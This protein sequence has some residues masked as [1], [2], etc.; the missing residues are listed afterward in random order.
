M[1]T[2]IIRNEVKDFKAW[3]KVF[4]EDQPKIAAAGAKL[5]GL[6]TSVDNPN[7]VTMIYEAPAAELYDQ[8][9]SDPER[10]AEIERAGVIGTPTVSFLK[11]AD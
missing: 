2:A 4:D 11:K 10:Q 7:E 8:L 3:K 1:V 6:Y 9:M 5:L